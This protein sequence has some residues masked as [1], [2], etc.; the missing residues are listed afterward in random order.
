MP[1]LIETV[2]GEKI[3]VLTIGDLEAIISTL[4]TALLKWI[5]GVGLGLVAAAA[6]TFTRLDSRVSHTE[7]RNATDSAQIRAL[8]ISGSMPLR[9]LAHDLTETRRQMA[10]LQASLEGLTSVVVDLR[11]QLARK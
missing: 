2:A 10:S 11:V 3:E 5:A 4:K 6:V 7:S 8:D 9:D 1:H